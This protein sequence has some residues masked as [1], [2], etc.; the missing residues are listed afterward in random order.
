LI[1]V[2]RVDARWVPLAQPTLYARQVRLGD[3]KYDVDRLH[4]RDDDETIR[5]VRVDHVAGVDLAQT[6]AA[7]DGRRDFRERQLQLGVVDLSLVARNRRFVLPYQRRLRVD[8]LL[9]NRVLCEQRLIAFEVDTRVGEQRLILC[10][11]SVHLLELHFE[12]A[13]IDFREQL[14]RFDDLPLVEEHAIQLAIDARAHGD[15]AARRY[16]AQSIQVDVEIA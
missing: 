12:R 7:R 1:A 15:G 5:V 2:V 13:R 8:L 10:H 14:T 16:G 3:R 9:G 4:L 11:L 6:K